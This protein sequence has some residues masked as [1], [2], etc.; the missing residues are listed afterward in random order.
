MI[1][2]AA[3]TILFPVL[4]A[5]LACATWQDRIEV[6]DLIAAARKGDHR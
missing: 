4:T 3:R 6:T 1:R 5:L 2:T